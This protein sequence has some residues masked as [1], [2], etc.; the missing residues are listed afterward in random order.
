MKNER[1][2]LEKRIKRSQKILNKLKADEKQEK[3]SDD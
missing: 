3:H 1:K 2:K